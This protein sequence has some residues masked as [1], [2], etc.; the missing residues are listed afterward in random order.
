MGNKVYPLRY[1]TV[2][3]HVIHVIHAHLNLVQYSHVWFLRS[4][5]CSVV[6][7]LSMITRTIYPQIAIYDI[8]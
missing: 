6:R 2:R 1:I 7:F 4:L 5:V 3:L 8:A